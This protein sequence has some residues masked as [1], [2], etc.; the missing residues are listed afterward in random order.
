MVVDIGV[1]VAA[2]EEVQEDG[3]GEVV[4]EAE[5]DTASQSIR[6]SWK[7]VLISRLV[8]ISNTSTWSATMKTML[9]QD[10]G[11]IRARAALVVMR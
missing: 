5:A 2:E 3:V 10:L 11:G 9:P 6:K 8:R 7:R 4:A 1:E